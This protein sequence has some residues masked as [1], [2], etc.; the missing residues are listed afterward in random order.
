MATNV[1]EVL[2]EKALTGDIP[3]LVWW[4][5]TR[6]MQRA[7]SD[8]DAP[9]AKRMA[10]VLHDEAMKGSTAAMIFWEKIPAEL[11]D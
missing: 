1:A 9:L 11:R 8:S 4:L 10:T 7:M 2:V 5:K 6:T 3:C